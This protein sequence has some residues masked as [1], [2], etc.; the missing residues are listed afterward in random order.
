MIKV[1]DN[2]FDLLPPS[3]KEALAKR[4]LTEEE[5]AC[6]KRLFE[7]QERKVNF[8]EP[9]FT[10]AKRA[11][12]AGEVKSK[13]VYPDKLYARTNDNITIDISYAP[14]TLEAVEYVRTDSFIDK[15]VEW[16]E[17]DEYCR[18]Q[19]IVFCE[20][21]MAQD[22]GARR[23]ANWLKSLKE[24]VQPQSQWKPSE[25][26]MEAMRNAIKPYCKGYGWEETALGTLYSDLKKLKGE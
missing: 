16:S 24:R 9:E 17:E 12:P 1:M 26:Q 21:C 19:L 6:Y 4:E 5:K 15:A 18:H 14:Q 3:L 13:F 25:E 2:L 23:C 11:E 22:S 20:K 8:S 10:K 7:I